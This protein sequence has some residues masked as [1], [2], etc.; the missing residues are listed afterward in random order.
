VG[1]GP[2][3]GRALWDGFFRAI[4]RVARPGKPSRLALGLAPCISSRKIPVAH[5]AT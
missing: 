5:G 1:K 2:V 4:C 3:F